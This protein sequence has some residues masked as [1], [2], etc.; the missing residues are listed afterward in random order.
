DWPQYGSL[1]GNVLDQAADFTSGFADLSA[2]GLTYCGLA[3]HDA[4]PTSSANGKTGT[5][6][7][8]TVAVGAPSKLVFTS[9]TN[10]VSSA[11]NKTL[12]AE[13]PYDGHNLVS[14]DSPTVVVFS[15]TAGAGSVTGLGTATA[16]S[17]IA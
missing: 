1:S 13:L 9:N 3:L 2:R 17:G 6:G 14:A 8:V 12:T 16:S 4:L 7:S 10:S 5:S 15:Q 11:A